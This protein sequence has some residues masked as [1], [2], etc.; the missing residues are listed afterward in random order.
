MTRPW[1]RP[2]DKGIYICEA[3]E[4]QIEAR[5]ESRAPSRDKWFWL[6]VAGYAGAA[7]LAKAGAI[8]GFVL[9]S[10]VIVWIWVWRRVRR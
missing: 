2:N 3:L 9:M 5:M 6:R 10:P 7:V 4:D 8:T 1:L